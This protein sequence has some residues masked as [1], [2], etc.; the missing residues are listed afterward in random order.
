[1]MRLRFTK[2]ILSGVVA[3]LLA[4]VALAADATTTFKVTGMYCN[5]C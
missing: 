3:L 1:M 2:V 5:A 4:N